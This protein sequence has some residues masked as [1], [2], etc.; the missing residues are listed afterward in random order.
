MPF[1]LNTN[2][3]LD[4]SGLLN[5]KKQVANILLIVLSLIASI[6]IYSRQS[7]AN[8]AI[9]EKIILEDKKNK[10][11]KEVG[12]SEQTISQIR[13]IL[14]YKDITSLMNAISNIVQGLGLR[15]VSVKPERTQEFP[16]YTKLYIRLML[17]ADD[18][19]QIGDLVANLESSANLYKV[20]ALKIEPASS[21][22]G[23]KGQ[24]EET[25]RSGLS[26]ELVVTRFIFKG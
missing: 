12:G 21:A 23:K 9:K 26:V 24:E 3:N 7:Q 17:G 11:L 19:H 6:N 15:I 16:M 22:E 18:Y 4:L 25:V 14:D 13:E 8:R 1:P 5:N 10:L 20:E 2:L